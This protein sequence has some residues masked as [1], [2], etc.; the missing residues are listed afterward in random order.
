[1]ESTLR[2]SLSHLPREKQDEL[3]DVLKIIIDL[4]HP[5]MVILFGS[6]A[7]GDWVYDRYTEEGI[8]YTYTSDYDLLV[9]VQDEHKIKPSMEG[10][11]RRKCR[12]EYHH[13]TPVNVIFHEIG[14]VN[15]ELE[16]G[17]YF[18]ADIKKEGVLIYDTGFCKLSEP[19][20]MNALEIKKKA[21][22][23]YK[24]WF[25]SANYFYE[26]Y[27]NNYSKE[28]Y[29]KAAFELHQAAERFLVTTLLVFTGY[30]PKTHDIML[31][32]HDVCRYGEK[33]RDIFPRNNNEENR[34]F[35]ILQK[36]YSDARYKIDYQVSP[37]DLENIAGRVEQ[38]KEMTEYYCKKKIDFI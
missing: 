15:K 7:R 9:I 25:E 20:S 13:S 16:E 8:T 2:T 30:K 36:A 27:L 5:E 21:T 26:D 34:I 23:Y 38:L 12:Q 1:M 19:G 18:F 10:K 11:I 4:T 31:L 33:F 14:F 37:E 6:H 17:N 3:E 28:R 24:F 32:Y 29:Q 22:D 35:N